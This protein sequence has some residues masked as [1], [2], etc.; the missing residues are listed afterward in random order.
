M[1][2]ALTVQKP[3]RNCITSV[4]NLIKGISHNFMCSPSPSI[5]SIFILPPFTFL[6]WLDRILAL[7]PSNLIPHIHL[8][9]SLWLTYSSDFQS[10]VVFYPT[11]F[12]KFLWSLNLHSSLTSISV[13]AAL[14]CHQHLILL[15]C[16]PTLIT[17]CN[18]SLLPQKLRTQLSLGSFF[19]LYLLKS[20]FICF[21][22]E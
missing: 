22:K 10:D 4:S 6:L 17:S 5:R 18:P 13:I 2:S 3:G 19:L 11:C 12:S 9:P 1:I 8:F 14:S 7:G 21:W 20:I 16:M 15:I